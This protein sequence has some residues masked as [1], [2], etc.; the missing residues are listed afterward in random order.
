MK[1]VVEK[2]AEHGCND[3]R[4][5]GR[6]G[7]RLADT[8][9]TNEPTLADS[10]VAGERTVRLNDPPPASAVSNSHARDVGGEGLMPA[11]A[12]SVDLAGD[13]FLEMPADNA[14]CEALVERRGDG[15][16]EKGRAEALPRG[17]PAAEF[18]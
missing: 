6:H 5:R 1:H 9:V 4:C 15:G 3:A 13:S 14:G 18:M 10:I 11:D 8:G 7:A 17:M 2:E 12:R 16:A